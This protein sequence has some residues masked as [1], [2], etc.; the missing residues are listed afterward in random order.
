MNNTEITRV[1]I[2]KYYKDGNNGLLAEV[3]VVINDC[4]MVHGITVRNGELGQYVAMPHTGMLRKSATSEKKFRELFHPLTKEF[5]TQL[6]KSVID[7]FNA[8][9]EE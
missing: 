1:V 5:Q 3:T 6:R 7:A 9:T 4:L 8:Y 2:D